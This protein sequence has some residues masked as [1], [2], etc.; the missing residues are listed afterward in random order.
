MISVKF[1]ILVIYSQG[2]LDAE[3]ILNGVLHVP[4]FL[5]KFVEFGQDRACQH[6]FDENFARAFGVEE[7][8]KFSDGSDDVKGVEVLLEILELGEGRH[9]FKDVIFKI[10][11]LQIPISN[12]IIKRYL[13]SGLKEVDFS[14]HVMEEWDNFYSS[15]FVS[16][17]FQESRTCEELAAFWRQH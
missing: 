5:A 2:G 6:V 15:I 4:S 12:R 8:E 10:L 3:P 17:K 1:E 16:L 13:N 9:Q 11:F 14:D 7:K